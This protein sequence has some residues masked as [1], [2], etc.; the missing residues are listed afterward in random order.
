MLT[1]RKI[2]II[3]KNEVEELLFRLGDVQEESNIFLRLTNK[4]DIK[5]KEDQ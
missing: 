5:C 4:Y 1:C 2:E 3:R